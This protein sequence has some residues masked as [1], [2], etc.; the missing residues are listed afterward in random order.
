MVSQ[1]S[2]RLH[3]NAVGS[4]QAVMNLLGEYQHRYR[5]YIRYTTGILL[6]LRVHSNT[7]CTLHQLH[8]GS[9]WRRGWGGV[10]R[11]LLQTLY[12][13]THTH[14][15]T[16]T[17][18]DNLFHVHGGCVLQQKKTWAVLWLWSSKGY[19]TLGNTLVL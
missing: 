12:I 11:H 3:H 7:P 1:K 6:K 16:H 9:G 10:M 18:L 17:C 19:L 8:N 4:L 15:H 14:T 13:N 2:D 5:D